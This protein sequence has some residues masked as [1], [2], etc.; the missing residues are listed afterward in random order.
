M[1]VPGL[2]VRR[3][4]PR[5]LAASGSRCWAEISMLIKSVCNTMR[6]DITELAIILVHV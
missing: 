6:F 5:G 2:A 1:G 3:W 4:S